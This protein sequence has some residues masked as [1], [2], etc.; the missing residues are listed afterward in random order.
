M[1]VM[2]HEN[3]VDYYPNYEHF[4]EEDISLDSAGKRQE[5]WYNPGTKIQSFAVKPNAILRL[6]QGQSPEIR[7]RYGTRGIFL[8]V[9]SAVPPWFHVDMR[10]GEEGA[11][12][13]ARVR[14]VH[15]QLWNFARGTF[16]GPVFGE[17]NNHAYW[18]GDLDGAEAQFGTGWPT[19]QGRSAPLD[20]TFDLLRIH[21]LQVNHGMGY[22][23]RWWSDADRASWASEIPLVI[24]DQY[25]MQE[26]AFGHAPFLG[27][28]TWSDVPLAWLEWSLLGPVAQRYARAFPRSIQYE[29]EG[30]L[31][32][33]TAA[34]RAGQ[35]NRLAVTYDNGLR[36]HANGGTESWTVERAT[37]PAFGW[38]AEAPGFQ[39]GTTLRDGMV[40]DHVAAPDSFFANARPARDWARSGLTR[41]RPT[42]GDFRQSGPRRIA[43][44][45]RW[46][47]REALRGDDI[48]FV[49]FGPPGGDE[50]PAHLVFQQDHPPAMPTSQWK[51]GTAVVD[52]PHELAI[53]DGVADG[54]YAWTIGLYD[55]KRGRRALEGPADAHGRIKL[56]V[57]QIR[58]GGQRITLVP[59][60][61]TGAARTA[62]YDEHVNRD[63]RLLDFGFAQTD[64]C[65]S[66]R[67]EGEAWV[68]RTWPRERAFVVKLDARRFP[69]PATIATDQGKAPTVTPR[70][71]GDHWI[72]PLNG[73]RTY[74]WG[75]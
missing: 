36:I 73:A 66:V 13:F 75:G 25:R 53:P 55:P 2:L 20:V 31:V 39:A 5:A 59:E 3:Y 8:D 28:E 34:A 15:R 9:H 40:S 6:A 43:F 61:D 67:R 71:E 51:V 65:L 38:L 1:P 41:V 42:L 69:M 32:D 33:A 57:L 58:E 22:Y 50:R 29:V 7:R 4:D 19:N 24:L 74:R 10:T 56:G 26:L 23:S 60:T 52:G 64:G 48:A 18:S 14:D 37:L 27:D 16:E 11:G 68:L 46:D 21:P 63:H 70:R 12:T 45:Y 47:V 72:L 35:W 17:G 49:H 30:R 44:T 62:L 54:D